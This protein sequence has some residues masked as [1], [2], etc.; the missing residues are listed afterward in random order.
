M[1]GTDENCLVVSVSELQPT[2]RVLTDFHCKLEVALKA[3]QEPTHWVKALPL[4]L[5][6]IRAGQKQDIGCST[7]EYMEPHYDYQASFSLQAIR[8]I[9]IQLHMLLNLSTS[10]LIYNL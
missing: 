3:T 9:R 6:D 8:N 10:C 5:L 7:A 2:I 4:V 1:A